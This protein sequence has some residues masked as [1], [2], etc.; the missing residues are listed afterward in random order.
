MKLRPLAL[1]A[2]VAAAATL[3]FVTGGS[4]TARAGDINT[5]ADVSSAP[6]TFSPKL[7]IKLEDPAPGAY[8]NLLTSFS[9]P[10]G[11]VQFA[12]AVTFLP[13]EWGIVKGDKVPIGAP[14]GK[15]TAE[16]TLGLVNGACDQDLPVEFEMFNASLNDKDTV[17]FYDDT[18][19]NNT[20]DFADDKDN[21]GLWDAID[22][23]PDFLPRLFDTV[24]IRRSAGVSIVASTP[25]LL[26]FLIFPPGTIVSKNI[27]LPHD[28]ELGYPSV[29]VLQAVG[30]TEATPQPGAI[31]DFCTPLV[32]EVVTLGKTEFEG[33]EYPLLINPTDGEYTFNFISAG[34]RD[35]DGDGFEN[36][37]DTC[38]YDKNVGDPRVAYVGDADNDGLDAVCDPNDNPD[39]GGTNSDQDGDGY[40]NRQDNCPLIANGELET[41][42]GGNQHDKDLD[43]IGDLC[44]KNPDNAD[45]EGKLLL[46]QP[47]VKITVGAGGSG[48]GSVSDKCT[49]DICYQLG[50]ESG[51]TTGGEGGGGGSSTAIIIVVVVIAAI[52]VLAG[53]A[54]FALR[55]RSGA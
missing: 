24:P 17:A 23:Y 55:R 25:V 35:A 41:G 13:Q 54:F 52:V 34:Q 39:Q 16:A 14:V 7:E 40:L 15:V 1:W 20:D 2:V 6:G 45:T 46:E 11:D 18:D 43:Q 8:S 10:K 50:K 32:S 5:D 38:P 49:S 3:V 28:K 9:I 22:K 53:G 30:D 31:T 29:T 42:P 12:G 48:P 4:D 47:T 36:S 37:F 26:Q 51:P 21:N 19:G 27:D 33:K 44:D